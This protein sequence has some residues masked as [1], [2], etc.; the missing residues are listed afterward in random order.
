M[1]NVDDRPFTIILSVADCLLLSGE[2]LELHPRTRGLTAA[3]T[4][5]GY[6]ALERPDGDALA[7]MLDPT[8]ASGTRMRAE[9][10]LTAMVIRNIHLGAG[11]VAALLVEEQGLDEEGLD[12]EPGAVYYVVTSQ[13]FPF[14]TAVREETNQPAEPLWVRLPPRP[15]HSKTLL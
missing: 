2:I 5:P 4:A 1:P 6:R 7:V 13:P 10:P 9:D 8:H 12:E 11:Y 3:Q 14:S 15:C